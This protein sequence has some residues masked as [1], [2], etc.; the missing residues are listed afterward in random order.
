[1]KHIML[2]ILPLLIASCDMLTQAIEP[3]DFNYQPVDTIAVPVDTISQ[4]IIVDTC[5]E[6]I[7]ITE[8]AFVNTTV[9]ITD[10][11][12]TDV[13]V[14]A[15][16]YSDTIS[17]SSNIGTVVDSLLELFLPAY[18]YHTTVKATDPRIFTTIAVGTNDHHQFLL[19]TLLKYNGL[20]HFFGCN[21]QTF[22]FAGAMDVDQFCQAAID[23]PSFNRINHR[24][25]E[26]DS[27]E[28][29]RIDTTAL[30]HCKAGRELAHFGWGIHADSIV[31]LY[32]LVGWNVVVTAA[33]PHG[34]ER[35]VI[36]LS[37]MRADDGLILYFLQ[38][39]YQ[40]ITKE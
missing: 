40:V 31:D 28:Y 15:G 10:V 36:D 12:T 13:I 11:V 27:L 26:F 32:K 37:G 19:K 22:Y 20:K 30:G 17:L 16:Q 25:T 35:M 23:Y 6:Y 1:M 7:E 5:E 29:E 24:G 34:V 18:E 3:D 14:I 38:Q 2:F 4:P 39:G 21:P 9:E 33:P 8:P